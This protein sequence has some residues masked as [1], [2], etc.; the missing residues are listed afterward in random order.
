[1][2]AMTVLGALSSSAAR[3]PASQWS[4]QANGG[5]VSLNLLSTLQISGGGSEA[6]AGSA[7]V[8]EASGH[9][10]LPLHRRI[11]EPL[12]DQCHVVALG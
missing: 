5:F 4:V 12:P 3:R 7:P 1:M 9:R 2:A 6:D 10:R 8:A 11:V